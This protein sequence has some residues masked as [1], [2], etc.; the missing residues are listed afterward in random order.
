MRHIAH[1]LEQSYLVIDRRLRGWPTLFI[2]TA[3]AFQQDAGPVVSRSIA[4]Y[5]L[6]S[7]FPLLLVLISVASTV[8]AT[9]EA[10]Q[11]VIGL[12]ER[13]LP[14][15]A[16]ATRRTIEQVLA[17]R[18]TVSAF[19]MLGLLWSASGVF[20]AVYRAVNKA[21]GNAKSRLFLKE[22]LFGLAVVVAFGLILLGISLLSTAV[23]VLQG[24]NGTILGWQPF[25]NPEV[26]ALWGKLSTFIPPVITVVTFI[27]L[28]WT[29]PSNLVTWRDVS[30]GGLLAGL[31]WELARQLY[32][33]YLANVATYSLVYGSVGAI[34]G[35]LLWSYLSAMI[36]VIGAEFTAQHTAWRKAGCP[37]ESLPLGQWVREWSK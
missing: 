33:W 13:I 21:W 28:Y 17:N 36:L 7:L 16:D 4:Y 9:E 25:S 32:A 11:A 19:A 23:N 6:F 15:A 26:A 2:R 10:Q 1:R 35:F 24:W 14:V 27:V 37:I 3:L 22:K 30:L 18:G 31:V 20:T 5:A 12:F 8:L 29:I 34:I